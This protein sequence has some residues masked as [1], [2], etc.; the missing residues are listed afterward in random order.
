MG[1]AEADELGV[2]P[3]E[4]LLA[5]CGVYFGPASYLNPPHLARLWNVVHDVGDKGIARGVTELLAGAEVAA[6]E[7]YGVVLGVVPEADGNDVGLAVRADG[8][9]AAYALGLEVGD[10][11]WGEDAHVGVSPSLISNSSSA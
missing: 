8:C 10:F 6:A 4:Y 3:F 5:A 7:V 2:G 9:Q 11:G 1:G